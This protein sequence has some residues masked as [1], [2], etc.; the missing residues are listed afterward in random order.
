VVKIVL[1]VDL[2]VQSDGEKDTDTSSHN[3]DLGFPEDDE[4]HHHDGLSS[5]FVTVI[6]VIFNSLIL[7]PLILSSTLA[8][9]VVLFLLQDTDYKKLKVAHTRLPSVWFWS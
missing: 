6:C 8:C 5:C 1:V 4:E 2:F 7:C 3:M 9:S